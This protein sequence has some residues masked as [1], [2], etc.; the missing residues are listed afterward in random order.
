VS[1]RDGCQYCAQAKALLDERGIDYVEIPLAHKIR[2]KALGAI[3]G[4]QT[5]P[6]VFIN[7]QRVGGLEELK[8]WVARA[9]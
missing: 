6:Q 2:S 5:V 4:A 1:T 7:G 9:A 8:R 3:A